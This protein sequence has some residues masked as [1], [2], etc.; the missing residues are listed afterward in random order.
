M[1]PDLDPDLDAAPD[2]TPGPTLFFSD[3]KD[4]KKNILFLIF[5]FEFN[6]PT[7]TLSLVL[8]I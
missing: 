4:A 3:F 1:D 8:E 5:F 7:G 6:L 2:P